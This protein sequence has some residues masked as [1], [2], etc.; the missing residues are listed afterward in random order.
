MKRRSVLIDTDISAG[1]PGAEID[2][3]AA[4][5]ALIRDPGVEVIHITTVYGNATVDTT[6][7]SAIDLVQRLNADIEV[8][9]GA[10]APLD[11]RPFTP[12]WE[13]TESLVSGTPIA[14]AANEIIRQTKIKPG[15]TIV[16]L[17]PLTNLALAVQR[18]PGIVNNIEHLYAMGGNRPP[19]GEFNFDADPLATARVLNAEWPMT[20]FGLDVTNQQT[21]TPRW[22]HDLPRDPALDLLRESAPAWIEQVRQNGW[23]DGGCAL[24]DAVPATFVTDP[25]IATTRRP[26]AN[27]LAELGIAASA[28]NLR[29]ATV[30]NCPHF[31]RR[32]TTLLT[33]RG[34]AP[35][36]S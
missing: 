24:H 34:P 32:L 2:D 18:E 26:N 31:L 9:S 4:V 22:F 8:T 30:L 6:T 15:L 36:N 5:I 25:N 12:P 10:E 28:T 23:H 1:L 3:A 16:A 19:T 33:R 27:Q 20:L 14:A 21:F 7:A 29:I 13:P 11:A 35:S 17:G